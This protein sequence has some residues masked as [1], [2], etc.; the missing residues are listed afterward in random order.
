MCD[1]YPASGGGGLGK[2]WWFGWVRGTRE[3]GGFWGGLTGFD[4]GQMFDPVYI[5][6]GLGGLSLFG[7]KIRN[8]WW[9]SGVLDLD[10]GVVLGN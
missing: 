6:K 4:R 3:K 10:Y 1:D 8:G 5:I 2:P 7:P 9:A